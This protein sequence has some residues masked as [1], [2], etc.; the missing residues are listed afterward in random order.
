MNSP[1]TKGDGTLL[2]LLSD[3]GCGSPGLPPAFVQG[4]LRVSLG[5]DLRVPSSSYKLAG[6][7]GSRE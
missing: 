7:I 3:R 2:S 5:A 1:E 4:C 6:A